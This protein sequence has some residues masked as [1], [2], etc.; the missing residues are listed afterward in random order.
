M[1]RALAWLF[2]ASMTAT[3]FFGM[4]ALHDWDSLRSWGVFAGC[5]AL[6][7]LF[8]LGMYRAEARRW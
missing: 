7:S 4:C 6:S 8:A 5:V 2:G 1:T 3:E